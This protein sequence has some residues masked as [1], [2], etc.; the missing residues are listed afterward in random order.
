MYLVF[1]SYDLPISNEKYKKSGSR[2]VKEGEIWSN[3]EE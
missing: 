1:I 3:W 2:G